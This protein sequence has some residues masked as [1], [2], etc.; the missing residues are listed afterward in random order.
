MTNQEPQYSLTYD[1]TREPRHPAQPDDG[2]Q[3]HA[4]PD[5]DSPDSA[6]AQER[7]PGTVRHPTPGTAWQPDPQTPVQPDPGTPGEDEM[8]GVPGEDS[9]EPS[10][11]H[12]S[13]GQDAGSME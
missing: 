2:N 7:R 6:G 3:G 13:S 10:M 9:R 4:R 12:G 1:P 8:V 11:P 5:D